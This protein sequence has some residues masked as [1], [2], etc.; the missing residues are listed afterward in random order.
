MTVESGLLS[1]RKLPVVKLL[2]KDLQMDAKVNHKVKNA[3]RRRR[4]NLFN[5][6][7]KIYYKKDEGLDTV[8]E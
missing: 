7:E 8:T 1:H 2:S 5:M 3:L 4:D 6:E